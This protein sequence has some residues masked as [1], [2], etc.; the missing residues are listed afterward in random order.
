MIHLFMK[1]NGK[2]KSV[3]I[4]SAFVVIFSCLPLLAE[5]ISLDID[6]VIQK[7]LSNNLSLK[8]EKISTDISKE[9]VISSKSIFDPSVYV[10]GSVSESD[11]ITKKDYELTQGI[12]KQLKTGGTASL[13]VYISHYDI[14]DINNPVNSGNN[15]GG[16]GDYYSSSTE[17]A[18]SQPLLKNRGT[19]INTTD[20]ALSENSQ[21]ISE[22]KFQQKVIDIIAEAQQLY[23][24]SFAADERL[25][26]SKQSLTLAQKFL[27]ESIEKVKLGELV[28]MDT[29]QAKAEVAQ[30]AEEVLLLE[31]RLKNSHDMLLY[32]IFGKAVFEDEVNLLQKPEFKKIE[33]NEEKVIAGGLERRTEYQTAKIN[34]E[35]S[36]LKVVYTK[37][38]KLPEVDIN[39]TI[40]VNGLKDSF[41][42]SVEKMA[43]SDNY[44]GSVSLSV[45]FP[46]GLRKDRTAYLQ[47]RLEKSRAIQALHETE[48][49]IILQIRT[50][51]RNLAFLEKKYSAS[52][53]SRKLSE[54][55]LRDEEKKYRHGL[56]TSYT[57]LQHQR[58]LA[59]SIVR[60]I[61]ALIEYQLA[62]VHLNKVAGLG[63]GYAKR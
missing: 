5:E 41:G 7:A 20:I 36:N 9:A 15:T 56:S 42:S 47:S 63:A 32:F 45:G 26:A 1:V 18:V 24:E 49:Q 12:S 34:I 11:N 2:M 62:I 19:D 23:W 57:V 13:N 30:R 31:N 50:A 3:L 46:W 27:D 58:D 6:N 61:D 25:K 43:G 40:T 28:Q 37:N 17:F 14:S 48:Q 4:I 59:L 29:L 22:L 8:I 10:R 38:Q 51:I 55:K 16:S 53:I 54:E 60:N 33:V 52:L 44:E 39:A 21:K 35:S